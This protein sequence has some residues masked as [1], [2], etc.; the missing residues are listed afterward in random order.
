[1]EK[2]YFLFLNQEAIDHLD[3]NDNDYQSLVDDDIDYTLYEC[4][5]SKPRAGAELLYAYQN[6]V[7]YHCL[8]KEEYELLN[9]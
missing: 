9:Q 2:E 7:T 3:D 4:D 6:F 1:M 5:L 8:T